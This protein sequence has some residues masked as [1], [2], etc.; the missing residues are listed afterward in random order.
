LCFYGQPLALR[1]CGTLT[2]RTGIQGPT[3]AAV[4]QR[5]Y[6]TKYSGEKP[7]G[8]HLTRGWLAVHNPPT[9]HFRLGNAWLARRGELGVVS[10]S[11]GAL[12]ASR[13]AVGW[14]VVGPAEGTA[15][16]TV[17]APGSAVPGRALMI[18]ALTTQRTGD[19]SVLFCKFYIRWRPIK[20][21]DELVGELIACRWTQ[22]RIIDVLW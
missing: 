19:C 3:R 16:S 21:S 22:A 17:P 14:A 11:R 10:V 1:G 18:R 2:S 4:R 13:A 5:P 8:T 12:P 7:A 9:V 15:S 6:C 20:A